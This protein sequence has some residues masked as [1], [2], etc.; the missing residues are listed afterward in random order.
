M[1]N[2]L[3]ISFGLQQRRAA[4][5]AVQPWP[6]AHAL[7]GRWWVAMCQCHIPSDPPPR[8]RGPGRSSGVAVCACLP[9]APRVAPP[10]PPDPA[11]YPFAP[12]SGPRQRPAPRISETEISVSFSRSGSSSCP[13]VGPALVPFLLRLLPAYPSHHRLPTAI[14]EK[15]PGSTEPS[16]RRIAPLALSVSLILTSIRASFGKVRVVFPLVLAF[17]FP[18][19]GVGCSV[20]RVWGELTRSS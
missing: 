11:N 8:A 2:N 15:G 14:E 20:V 9:H 10:S 5:R 7:A 16:N 13:A 6:V 1:C 4:L 12:S 3:T 17:W 19:L 18:A